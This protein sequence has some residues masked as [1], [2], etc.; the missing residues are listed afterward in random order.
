MRQLSPIVYRLAFLFVI[1]VLGSCIKDKCG[2]VICYNK[3]VCVD[4]QC[5]CPSGFEG[6]YCDTAWFEK[7]KGTWQVDETY[8]RDTGDAHFGYDLKIVGAA[9]SF[10]ITG[11][12]DS[13]NGVVCKRQSRYEFSIKANQVMRADSSIIIRGG[14]GKM[15]NDLVTGVYSF[16]YKDTT[17]SVNF[18]WKR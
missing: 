18:K 12:H 17:L 5:A 3:G 13:L 16:K 10:T 8:V 1:L 6:L 2:K 7:F 11:L 14:E 4:G 15:K 9:D